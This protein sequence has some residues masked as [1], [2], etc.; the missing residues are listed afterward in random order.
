MAA[1]QEIAL[2][3]SHFCVCVFTII[4]ALFFKESQLFSFIDSLIQKYIIILLDV[5]LTNFVLFQI[6]K[7]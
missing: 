3:S 5:P 2:I 6:N 1:K 7:F 4:L